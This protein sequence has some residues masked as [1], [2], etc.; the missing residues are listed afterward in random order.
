MAGRALNFAA[1][2]RNPLVANNRFTDCEGIP[3]CATQNLGSGANFISVVGNIF[4]DCGEGIAEAIITL[5]DNSGLIVGNRCTYEVSGGTKPEY[6]LKAN[7]N[8]VV[9]CT[10]NWLYGFATGY[11][12]KTTN[13]YDVIA[14][15]VERGL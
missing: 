12:N 2:S 8:Q 14:N 5:N 1:G 9:C 13:S 15:N 3:V 4:K 7:S 11:Y 10:G 6:F